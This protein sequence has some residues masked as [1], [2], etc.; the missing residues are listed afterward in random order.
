MKESNRQETQTVL[1]NVTQ[2]DYFERL[3]LLLSKMKKT[4]NHLSTSGERSFVDYDTY[5]ANLSMDD[6]SVIENDFSSLIS[7]ISYNNQN[8]QSNTYGRMDVP[9]ETFNLFE[10]IINGYVTVATAL[11]GIFT[12]ILAICYISVGIRKGKFFYLLL[13]ALFVADLIFLS[14]EIMRCIELFFIPIPKRYLW[15][16]HSIVHSGIRCS[17]SSSVLF[18]IVIARARYVAISKPFQNPTREMSSNETKA[19]FMKFCIPVIV[20]SAIIA[21]TVYFE[22]DKDILPVMYG[23]KTLIP[24]PSKLRLNLLYLIFYRGFVNLGLLGVFPLISL[25]YYNYNLIRESKKHNNGLWSS[26]PHILNIRDMQRQDLTKCLVSIIFA[27]IGLHSLRIFNSFREI[28]RLMI[29]NQN[30]DGFNHGND[31]VNMFYYTTSLSEFL[32]KTYASINAMIYLF[33][34]LSKILDVY[35]PPTRPPRTSLERRRNA[36]IEDIQL[37][38]YLEPVLNIRQHVANN[39]EDRENYISRYAVAENYDIP[40]GRQERLI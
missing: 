33:P 22:T 14:L 32:M 15:I 10:L 2:N 26:C 21:S 16:Y 31:N 24:A 18:L 3:S 23:N 25:M 38:D 19:K 28:I 29:P 40:I 17:L 8:D 27:F 37:T 39:Y 9:S 7:D 34:N 36:I 6:W 30:E 20:T 4:Q 11:I 1:T 12:N 5:F 13:T 35:M